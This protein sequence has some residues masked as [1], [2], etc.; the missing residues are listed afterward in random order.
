M[1]DLSFDNSAVLENLKHVLRLNRE[2]AINLRIYP[3]LL[4]RLAAKI[5]KDEIEQVYHEYLEDVIEKTSGELKQVR[6]HL[7]EA[8]R[9][10]AIGR[11]TA[12]VGHVLR[13][14]LQA[15]INT[16]YLARMKR[17]LI[18]PQIENYDVEDVYNKIESQIL[19]MDKIVTGLQN[20]SRPITLKQVKTDVKELVDDVISAISIPK[21][22]KISVKINEAVPKVQVDS[23]S[24]KRLSYNLFLNAFQAMPNGDELTVDVHS[25]AVSVI[26]AVEDTG[27]GI[28]Q[29]NMSK[30]FD[31]FFTTK[32]QRQG[33]GLS[34]CKRFVEANGGSIE[35]KSKE[36]KGTTFK[37]K[38]PIT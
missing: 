14:P 20:F 25:T 8:E 7:L 30:I 27:V 9:L 6:S 13:N 26:V 33:L 11:T 17:E 22:I 34:I 21:N 28:S 1:G 19:Y 16:L 4:E 38:L 5:P 10:S 36:G 24:V 37:V 32:A 35:V 2:K 3:T 12:M 31:P 18:P 23:P 29:Q 15:I